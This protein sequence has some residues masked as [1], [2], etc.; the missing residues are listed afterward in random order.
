M[1]VVL[2][3]DSGP[4]IGLGH[5]QRS[6][7]L[8]AALSDGGAECVLLTAVDAD[9][10]ERSAAEGIE[11]LDLGTPAGSAADVRRTA[12]VAAGGVVV[13]DSYHADAQFLEQLGRHAAVV[14]IDDRAAFSFPF[15]CRV[16]VNGSPGAESLGYAADDPSTRFLLG[17][18]YA[19]LR[20]SL[21]PDPS[22]RTRPQVERI[23]VTLGGSDAHDLMP[24]LC[25]VVAA[26]V[27]SAEV[28]AVRGPFFGTWDP[29]RSRGLA[30]VDAPRE[31]R[32]V[33]E[34]ADIVVSAGGQ[35]ALE[36]C[37]LGVPTVVVR[38]AANQDGLVAGLVSADAVVDTGPVDVDTPA[39][40]A[41]AVVSLARDPERRSSL[42]TAARALVDGR[43]ALRVAA[44]VAEEL[45][46]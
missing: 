43:G 8:G 46:S 35:T 39:R 1:R 16:V 19:L 5:L 15:P 17:T 18:R 25:A 42:S 14:A 33:F 12:E 9:V 37:R 13:V 4:G 29:E 41:H 24:E 26:A 6:L 3:A 31:L 45:G 11:V 34:D 7:A 32:P 28:L 38:T 23:V 30:L 20:R 22:G 44:V 21:W 40:T 10:M 2:R 36:L 27:P